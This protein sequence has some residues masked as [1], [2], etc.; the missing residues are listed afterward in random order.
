[1]R[2]PRDPS[3][4]YSAAARP[5]WRNSIE[6]GSTRSRLSSFEKPCDR[7]HQIGFFDGPPMADDLYFERA[8]D[9][10][11]EADLVHGAASRNQRRRHGEK[12]VARP[13]RVDNV[14]GESRDGVDHPAAFIGDTAVLT[15]GDDHL[16]AADQGLHATRDFADRPGSAAW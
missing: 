7:L 11:D 2:I 14:L 15:L 16:R 9:I 13:H 8:N 4:R 5:A 10:A 12:G 1:M 3:P 6:R